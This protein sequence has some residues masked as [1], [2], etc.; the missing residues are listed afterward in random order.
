MDKLDTFTRLPRKVSISVD[1]C[2][3]YHSTLVQQ[4][5]IGN[6]TQVL[7]MLWYIK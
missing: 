7:F 6:T 1:T 4:Q 2:N 5:Y 3:P